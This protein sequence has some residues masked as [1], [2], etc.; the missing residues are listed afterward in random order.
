V[1]NPPGA[2]R[3][4]GAGFSPP[5]QQPQAPRPGGS[6]LNPLTVPVERGGNTPGG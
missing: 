3:P 4:G 6:V 1:L 2:P 5:Q